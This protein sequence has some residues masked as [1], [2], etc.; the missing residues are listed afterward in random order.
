MKSAV[1]SNSF[2][3]KIFIYG[4]LLNP[5]GIAELKKD[6]EIKKMVE[7]VYVETDSQIV[8]GNFSKRVNLLTHKTVQ[9]APWYSSLFTKLSLI[10]LTVTYRSHHRLNTKKDMVEEAGEKHVASYNWPFSYMK[11]PGKG[12]DVRC[13]V[14]FRARSWH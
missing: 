6:K 8:S 7:D 1:A 10:F 4:I 12:I 14:Y 11:E 13:I 9:N 5:T 3:S 2:L